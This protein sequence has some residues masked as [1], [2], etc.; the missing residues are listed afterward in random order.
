MA[1]KKI[2]PLLVRIGALDRITKPLRK[3]NN[4]I[5]LLQA[6]VLKLKMALKSLAQESG[7]A[8]LGSDI[9]RLG[10]R[11]TVAAAVGGYAF[12]RMFVDIAS[13]FERS[14]FALDAMTGGEDSGK[15]AFK[16]VQQFAMDAPYTFSD[17]MEVYKKLKSGNVDPLSPL[18]GEG[19]VIPMQALADGL[20]HV[21]GSSQEFREL[22]RQLGQMVGKQ[23]ILAQDANSFIDRG[24]NPY[25]L[26]IN[27]IQDEK[28]ITVSMAE[29]RKAGEDGLLGGGAV[30]AFLTQMQKETAGS[31]KKFMESWSG[32]MSNLRD[33]WDRFV[34][35][36]MESGPFDY[37]K[38][39]AKE[40]IA[41][42][43]KMVD[44]GSMKRKAE[45]L[46]NGFLFFLRSAKGLFDVVKPMAVSLWE[47]FVWIETHIGTANA[48]FGLMA[49]T[50]GG[51]LIFSIGLLSAALAMMGTTMTATF[52]IPGLIVGAIAA[53]GYVAYYIVQ[54]WSVVEEFFGKMWDAIGNTFTKHTDLL[55]S[56]FTGMIEGIK[57]DLNAV[58]NYLE[59]TMLGKLLTRGFNFATDVNFGGESGATAM[60][61]PGGGELHVVVKVESDRAGVKSSVEKATGISFELDQGYS[62]GS[63]A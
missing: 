35:Y 8:K 22:G 59:N 15:A 32:M 45:E 1:A 3:I 38:A 63:F 19:G 21:G 55:K 5:K 39:Q 12:K 28:G 25:Q 33:Y 56:Q 42:L 27:Y 2:F 48:A 40:L 6:P 57:S 37:M 60:L 11:L 20:A 58:G 43:S 14:R 51:K 29:M 31:A 34:L 4:S 10:K 54:Q 62:S 44:D 17:S 52:L 30:T 13:D 41:D 9:G 24:I 61:S 47:T 46:A 36:T 53:L 23:K 26:L 50:I 49:I 16:N 7:I 18:G